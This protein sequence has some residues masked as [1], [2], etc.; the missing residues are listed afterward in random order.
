MY[1]DRKGWNIQI[2][3]TLNMLQE[4]APEL[5]PT[6]SRTISFLQKLAEEQRALLIA[7]VSGF[8]KY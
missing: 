2:T 4:T 6:I 7:E 1:I 3:I 8:L 5:E